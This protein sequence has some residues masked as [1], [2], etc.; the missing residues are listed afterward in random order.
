MKESESLI[1]SPWHSKNFFAIQ[2]NNMGRHIIV[3]L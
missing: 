3:W 2:L 1:E